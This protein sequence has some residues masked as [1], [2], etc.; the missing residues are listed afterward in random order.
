MAAKRRKTDNEARQFYQQLCQYEDDTLRMIYR[1]F[2]DDLL[3]IVEDLRPDL[4]LPKLRLRN[5][6]DVYKYWN[7]T[8]DKKNLARTLIQDIYDGRRETM[9][10]FWS[11]LYEIQR[12]YYYSA[13]NAVLEE[14]SK[15]G[16]ILVEQMLLDEHGP[17]LS[18][19]LKEI[20][21]IHKNHLLE[22]TK[23]FLEKIPLRYT[24][25]NESFPFCT[26]HI[27][28]IL[29]SADH[30]RKCSENEFIEIAEKHEQYLKKTQNKLKHIKSKK[31][32][33]WCHQS[34]LVPHMVMVSGVPGV[35][36]TTLM[37]KIVYDWVKGDFYQRFSFVFLFKFWELN[38]MDE[39]S[40]EMLILRQYPYLEQKLGKILED[41]EK[42]LFIFDGLEESRHKMDFTSRDFSSNP[43]Q[44]GKCGQIV[45]SLMRKSLLKGCYVLMTSRPSRLAHFAC[46]VFQRIVEIA[47]FFPEERQMY[48][49]KIFPNHELA[50]KAFN[51]VKQNETLYTL[52][53]LPFYCWIICTVLS[54]CL[55]PTS[56]D[57]PEPLLP[58]TVTQV[59]TIYVE[60]ILSN[61][62]LHKGDAQK[63]LRSIGW[64]AEHGVMNLRIT[65]DDRDL[66]SFHVD[67]KSKLLP[68]FL[69]KSEE[70]V[71]YS[72]LHPIVQDFFSALV[73]YVDYSAEKLQ[74]SLEEA[75]SYSDGRGEIFLRFLCGLSDSSTRSILTGYLDT[76]DSRASRDVITWLKNLIPEVEDLT[77]IKNKRRLFRR[78]YYLYEARNMDLVLES[79]KF[80]RRLDLSDV[81]MSPADCTVLTFILKACRN[82]EELNFSGCSLDTE[83]FARFAQAL[84]NLQKLSLSFKD[85]SDTYCFHLSSVIRNN[86]SLKILNM[87]DNRM[88]GPYFSDLMEAIADSRIEELRLAKNNLPDISCIHLASVIRNNKSLKILDLSHNSLSGPHFGELMEAL[89]TPACRIQE[90]L[91]ARNNLS[92]TSCIKLASAIRNNRS[93]KT[94]DLTGN[95]LYG[96]DYSDLMEA[97]SSPDCRI[98]ELRLASNNLPDTSCFFLTSLI[99]NNPS[100][101]KLDLAFNSLY[102]PYFGDLIDAISSRDC[103][104]EELCLGC[105]NLVDRSCIQL[106][107]GIRNNRS[108]KMLD[109]SDNNLYGPHF[110]G[111][112]EALSSADCRIEELRLA[113]NKLPDISCMQL[114]SLIRNNRSLKKLDLTGNRLS[115]PQFSDLMEVLASPDCR[116]EELLLGYNNLPDTSCMQLTSVLKNNPFVKK[117]DLTGNRRF[118]PEKSD[119]G[120]TTSIKSFNIKGESSMFPGIQVHD[121]TSDDESS[122][123]YEISQMRDPFMSQMSDPEMSQMSDPE[124][125]QMSIPEMSQMSDPE[126]SQMSNPELSQMSEM[127][128]EDDMSCKLCEKSQES[129]EVITPTMIG[130][131]YRLSVRSSGLFRC[132]ET[133]IQFSVTQP[134]T[135]EYE[136]DSWSNYTEILQNLPEKYEIIGPLFN[137]KSN[138]GT[139][140]VSAVYLPHCLCLGG[141]KGEKSLI[142]CFHYK[143]DNMAFETPSRIEA[144]YAVME[145][146]TFSCIG[147]ILYP[148]RLFKEGIIK[149]I[150]CHGMVLLFYNTIIKDDLYHMYRLHLY[151]LPRIRTVEKEVERDKKNTLFQRIYKPPQTE[152]VYSMKN[153]RINGPE[154]AN[155]CP[156][157]LLFESCPPEVYSFTEIIAEGETSTKINLSI[158]SEDKDDPI[159]KSLVSAGEMIN[160]PSAMSGRSRPHPAQSVHFLDKHRAELISTIPDTSRVLDDLLDLQ[161]LNNEQYNTV[162]TLSQKTPEEQMRKLYDYI[163]G[164]SNEDKDKVY[165][166]LKT[167]H[168]PIIKKLKN[169]DLKD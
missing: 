136:V 3:Y 108:L 17:Q 77:E 52:C 30:F 39:V 8:N 21:V 4:L 128:E 18:P 142:K 169:K 141:F 1:Y 118:G 168:H 167:Y 92:D 134:V 7:L 143:D 83:G 40:L 32:F 139:N 38:R 35:G 27:N 48:F 159:W 6:P 138:V 29:V 44:P 45:L 98:E 55:Q 103:R 109:L 145:N 61:Q 121:I 15:R 73:H 88:Y 50:E 93:L 151:L 23:T 22:E 91:L 69:I 158:L 166:S 62:S 157:T 130:S 165:Q 123:K 147:I 96:P 60:I 140:V 120:K 122:K 137:I 14:L 47:G 25:G 107:S 20:Q 74:R 160:L 163:R 124:F 80:H 11:D 58:K 156:E 117:L 57:Q 64:M 85:P 67:S 76:Q 129:L 86:Q 131:T 97:L 24:K 37:E 94:L 89:S 28:L 135:L 95:H 126:F 162:L 78:F 113:R 68:S 63:I 49:E 164:F 114:A 102:G 100:L 84:H 155:V 5:I 70:P 127:I 154:N 41:P 119:L 71:T 51:Y 132:L 125:S 111:L 79:L 106:A 2:W 152:T 115:G 10:G 54:K 150:P 133:G 112:M 104:I 31:I 59:F 101:K 146:P 9:I 53:Y 46:N 149:R 99:R 153:Y 110:A 116:I 87:S 75:K 148:L 16:N 72:F 34:R 43:K 12:N 82:I 56:S 33:H 66:G 105:N 90:L 26:H 81:D 144:M 36:K 13:L 42:I 161:L 65:F 19:E